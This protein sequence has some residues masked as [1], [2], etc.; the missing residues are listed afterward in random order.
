M[1]RM[2]LA[3]VLGLFCL[4][5]V[6]RPPTGKLPAQQS[7]DPRERTFIARIDKTE[8][9]Y[10]E[11]LPE[12]FDPARPHGLMLALHGHGSDRRQYIIDNRGECRGAREMAAKYGM[13]YVSPDYRAT[14]SWM[15]PKA[16]ADMVQLIKQ[17]K[18]QYKISKVVVV[19]AS[20]GGTSSLIF[21][22]RHPRLV[23]GVVSQNGMANMIEYQNFQNAIKESYGGDKK[24]KPAEYKKRSA[25]FF[26]GRFT[27]PTAITTG[28][29]DTLVPPQS[30]LRLAAEIKKRNL[31]FLLIH[32][33]ATGHTTSYE[34]TVQA[35]DFVLSRTF[36]PVR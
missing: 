30:A 34:D 20:M 25:E 14:T 10:M 35:M 26:P 18:R 3:G 8:Q 13:I 15:G 19:G 33:E 17:L 11:L 16:D 24:Q 23:Q 27:M 22:A 29:Q 2:I 31:N 4:A 28:G 32:R 21:T 12:P 1:G 9:H 5:C 6:T 36:G 7:G